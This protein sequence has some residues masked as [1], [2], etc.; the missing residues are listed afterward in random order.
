MM[1]TSISKKERKIKKKLFLLIGGLILHFFLLQ[2]TSFGEKSLPREGV[3]TQPKEMEALENKVLLKASPLKIFPLKNKPCKICIS[4]DASLAA[5]CT[6]NGEILIYNLEKLTLVFKER[7]SSIPIY[8]IDFHPHKNIL[9]FGDSG[10]VINILDVDKKKVIKTIYESGEFISDVRYTP[11]GTILGIA[12]FAR[13]V[14][15]Y[16]IEKFRLLR[17]L[18]VP[19][20]RIY[21]LTFSKDNALFAA[22]TRDKGVQIALLKGETTQMLINHSSLVLASDWHKANFFTSGGSDGQIFLYKKNGEK[23]NNDF[24]F[25]WT[26]RDW[27]TSL[28]FFEELLITGSKD[29]FVRVFDFENK[30][31]LKMVEVAHPILGIDIKGKFLCVITPCTLLV[32]RISDILINRGLLR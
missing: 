25:W 12:H 26:H 5:L 13:E 6:K 19:S 15:F 31:L 28:K 21:S 23:I 20:I 24:F 11:D 2:L 14:T 22:C 4:P 16:D 9:A 10:G 7:F 17:K 8:G 27:V 18:G 30:R 32:Y 3:L 29:G 1:K